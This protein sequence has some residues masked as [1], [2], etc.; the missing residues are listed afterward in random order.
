[1]LFFVSTALA[2]T[3]TLDGVEVSGDRVTV[4]PLNGVR[5]SAFGVVSVDTNVG[6]GIVVGDA[7]FET[8]AYEG[9]GPDGLAG[10][11]LAA[12][13]VTTATGCEADGAGLAIGADGGGI[14]KG[15][16]HEGA[17]RYGGGIIKGEIIE[18]AERRGGGIIKGQIQEG[19]ER[20]GGGIIKG[21]IIEGAER[22]GGGII[23]GHILEGA[24]RQGGGVIRGQ[25]LEGAERLGGLVAGEIAEGTEGICPID[26]PD[27]LAAAAV[28]ANGRVGA[29]VL[30]DGQLMGVFDGATTC[31]ATISSGG[32][33]V[34]EVEGD[35]SALATFAEVPAPSG[36]LTQAD[37]GV[38]VTLTW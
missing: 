8:D 23:K 9:V 24:E 36:V 34:G 2:A 3:F 29:L 30:V 15:Q 38:S 37:G 14:I 11:P 19:A 26:G 32:E 4:M 25:I 7:L 5:W 21:Q 22:Q 27:C 1:M 16:I 31:Q 13:F 35:C 28:D 20:L 12:R 10:V 33:V 17:E 6:E 18:G